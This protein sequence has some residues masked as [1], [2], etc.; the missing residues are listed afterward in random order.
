MTTRPS[1][2]STSPDCPPPEDLYAWLPTQ[3]PTLAPSP[4]LAP[5]ESFLPI[6]ES[7]SSQFAP[8]ATREGS[9]MPANT[10]LSVPSS[11]QDKRKGKGA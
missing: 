2:L 3:H 6:P 9:S 7:P 10:M 4:F 5:E 11:P 1:H 8:L